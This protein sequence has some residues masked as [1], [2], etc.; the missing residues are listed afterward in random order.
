MINWYDA[1][2]R[3]EVDYRR[4]R[5]LP[6]PRPYDHGFLPRRNH[7]PRLFRRRGGGL[8]AEEL[9]AARARHI[10]RQRREEPEP[11]GR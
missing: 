5:E 10:P 2:L 11:A 7:R 1:F 6:R 9:V 8:A 4:S 3:A